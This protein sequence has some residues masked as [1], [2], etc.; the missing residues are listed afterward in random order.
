MKKGL[1]VLGVLS[2]MVFTSCKEDAASKV[3]EANVE[4]AAARD[5]KATTYPVIV[6]DET[7]H[8]FNHDR[9]MVYRLR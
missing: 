8:D 6:F 5:A 9:P 4:V 3:N 2:A 1:L 7:E